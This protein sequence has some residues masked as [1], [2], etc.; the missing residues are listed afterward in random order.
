[1]D[2]DNKNSYVNGCVFENG[3]YSIS[4]VAYTEKEIEDGIIYVDDDPVGELEF[5]SKSDNRQEYRVNFQIQYGGRD[6]AY[7]FLMLIDSIKLKLYLKFTD[8]SDL[9]LYSQRILVTTK[10]DTDQK[11]INEMICYI[12]SDKGLYREINENLE[13]SA[14]SIGKYSEYLDR[15]FLELQKYKFR[16]YDSKERTNYSRDYCFRDIGK[17][18]T[19]PE[20]KRELKFINEFLDNLYYETV[21]IERIFKSILYENKKQYEDLKKFIPAEFTAPIITTQ[22]LQ[23][24]KGISEYYNLTQNIEKIKALRRFFSNNNGKANEARL[25]KKSHKKYESEKIKA[26]GS[27]NYQRFFYNIE[28]LDKLYE[29]YCLARILNLLDEINYIPD[30]EKDI[31]FNYETG[32]SL[33]LNENFLN[34]TFYR[35]KG[36]V[37]LTLYFQ[38]VVYRD[39]SKNEI[40]LFRTTGADKMYTPFNKTGDYYSPDFIIKFSGKRDRYLILDSKFQTRN[41]ILKRDMEEVISKYY[42]QLRD[43]NYNRSQYVYVLQGRADENKTTLWNYENFEMNKNNISNFGIIHF[44]PEIDNNYYFINLISK[45]ENEVK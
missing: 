30:R 29:Y 1:M 5:V 37:N 16:Y 2:I 9:Y 22:E 21:K 8:D 34:N 24:K 27:L 35:K 45:L 11:S 12:M 44:S 7:P 33:F 31:N 6:R 41:T 17:N 43:A 25:I 20:I 13:F 28:S 40:G 19:V 32:N 36:Y 10:N 26:L 23:L 3:L 4:Y 18:Y 38:P 15:V 42:V 14:L 39:S